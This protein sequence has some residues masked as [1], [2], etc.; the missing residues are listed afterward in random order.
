MSKFF[1]LSTTGAKIPSIAYGTG[2]AWFKYGNDTVDEKL[3]DSILTAIKAG[4]KHIDGAEVYGTDVEVGKAIKKSGI[5]REDLWFTEKYFAGDHT[6]SL[7]SPDA[8]P[9]E[10][11]KSCLKR[12]D[13]E[14]VDLFLLHSPFIKKEAYGFTLEEA[15]G[16]AEKLQ[17]L[18]LAK[19]IGVSNFAVTDLQKILPIAKVKP[20][21]N[22]IEHSAYLANQTPGIV[23]FCQK[24]GILIEAYSPLG[25]LTKGKPGPL[26]LVIEKLT[27][28]Y[29]KT[30]S[31]I[32]LRFTLQEGILPIT[33]TKKESRMKEYLEIFDFELTADEFAEIATVGK[34]KIVR[35]YFLGYSHFDE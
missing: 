19:N 11:L 16:Y 10:S 35:Q 14:Y 26:D 6:Y 7:H 5:K 2:T 27:A 34:Q 20:Q 13:L 21:V 17:E 8:N 4:F 29:G 23:E 25:P 30:D 3:V 32:L 9:L 1:T 22:Q 12:L 28:K 24:E 18:G 31:Q 15:W 33:T